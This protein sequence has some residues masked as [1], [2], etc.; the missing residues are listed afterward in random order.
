MLLKTKYSHSTMHSP[1]WIINCEGGILNLLDVSQQ[2][3]SFVPLMLVSFAG[4]VFVF[5]HYCN[6]S[7]GWLHSS[8]NILEL[9]VDA[10][11]AGCIVLMLLLKDNLFCPG[12]IVI[13]IMHS[14]KALDFKFP[15]R[16]AKFNP[17]FEFREF[18]NE[19][20]HYLFI[21]LL[22]FKALKMHCIFLALYFKTDQRLWLWQ[23][24]R[25]LTDLSVSS[26]FHLLPAFL[27]TD[28]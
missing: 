23:Q 19:V 1:Q 16:C 3:R 26:E 25:S 12:A 13:S 11:K 8:I 7:N 17:L 22:I 28:S 5:L 24:P 14:A 15:L 2:Y 4:V 20:S 10:K 18:Y 27:R 6:Q 9:P 21:Y